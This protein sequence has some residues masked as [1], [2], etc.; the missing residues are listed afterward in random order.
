MT[1]QTAEE[2]TAKNNIIDRIF[3]GAGVFSLLTL[4][5]L[6]LL[7]YIS[8]PKPISYLLAGAGVVFVVYLVL[9]PIYR[10]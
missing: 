4:S 9:S 8:A 1:K 7:K 5:F 2:N 10:K 6:G 3:M